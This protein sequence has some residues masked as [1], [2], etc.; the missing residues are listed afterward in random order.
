MLKEIKIKRSDIYPDIILDKE[1]GIFEISGISLPENGKEF[2]QPVLDFLSEYN[3]KPNEVTH[4]VFN[5][6]FFNISSSKMILFILFKLRELNDSGKTVLVTW[7]YDDED[8]HE[9]GKDFEHMVSVPFQFKEVFL[10]RLTG[11]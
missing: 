8:I 7:C 1:N 2:Y 11:E 9:A 10:E 4:F 6:R 3:E 5:L